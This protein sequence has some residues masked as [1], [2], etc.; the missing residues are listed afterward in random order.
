MCV[1]TSVCMQVCVWEGEVFH[2]NHCPLYFNLNE[3]AAQ[4]VRITRGSIS[5]VSYVYLPQ[6]YMAHLQMAGDGYIR[7]AYQA[8]VSTAKTLGLL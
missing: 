5:S 1:R 6:Q 8:D 2:I 7:K 3:G 4:L